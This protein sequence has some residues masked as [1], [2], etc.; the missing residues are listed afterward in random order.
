MTDPLLF[1]DG[2]GHL[3]EPPTALID[4]A[5]PEHKHHI[6]QVQADDDGVEWL[7][8]EDMRMEAAVMALA[9]AGGFSEEERVR[10]HSGQMGYADLPDYCWEAEARLEALDADDIAHSVLYPTMLLTFQHLRS[11][12]FAEVQCRAY[13]DWLSDVCAKGRGRLHGVAILPHLDP[14]RAAREVRRVADLPHIVG[15]QVRPNPAMDFKHLN[16][17]VYEPIWA[18]AE[19]VGLPV[20][21]HPLCSADLPGAIRGLQLNKLGTSDIPVQ[22]QDD[23]GS[24][25]IFFT[26]IIGNP[27]DMMTAVTFMTAGGVLQR[28]PGLKVAFLEANGGWIVPWLERLDHHFEI[29]GWDVPWLEMAPSAYFRRQC[30][31]SFD[32]DESTLAFTARSPLVGADRILWASDFPHPDAKHPGTTAMLAE[33]IAELPRAD[34][35]RIAG[36]NAADLYGLDLEV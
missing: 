31:I 29:Y 36:R 11:L 2:D 18:A 16:H 10:S 34:Q 33:S 15:V 17:D 24:D 7:V 1:V 19:E 14:E 22:D 8:L 30:W 27:V 5:P 25:N 3:L 12:E 21:L 9:A 13:N 35:E 23:F 20:G 32:V 4:Y 28:H 6:W 26:Q